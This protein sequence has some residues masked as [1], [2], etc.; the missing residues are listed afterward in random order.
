MN[1]NRKMKMESCRLPLG[2]V[3][4]EVVGDEGV[5]PE[6]LHGARGAVDGGVRH[7]LG[8][9]SLQE[10][11]LV[12]H[13]HATPQRWVGR[14]EA[15]PRPAHQPGPRQE[16]GRV[17]LP[18]DRGERVRRHLRPVAGLGFALAVGLRQGRRRHAGTLGFG[19]GRREREKRYSRRFTQHCVS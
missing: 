9:L 13:V 10:V 3:A 8:L 14:R 4:Q 2:H 15:A 19:G 11:P 18:E 6:R 7:G 5:G 17:Q 1:Q 16:L 12:A